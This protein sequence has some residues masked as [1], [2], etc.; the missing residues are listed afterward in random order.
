MKFILKFIISIL[1]PQLVGAIGA[2]FTVTSSESWYQNITKPGFTPP[3]WIFGPVW[4][5]LYLLMGL[6]LF[7]IW[8]SEH[9]Y[10]RYGLRL[11]II[12]LLLNGIWSPLFFGLKSP[13]LGLIVIILLFIMII[14]CIKYFYKINKASSY[15]MVPYVIWVGFAV[16]LNAAI[17][18]MNL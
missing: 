3:D 17:W 15:L 12:Q 8:T 4:I 2:I 5:S 6:S 14:L 9:P 16:L 10:K 7:L 13:F 11:F 1:I 18:H